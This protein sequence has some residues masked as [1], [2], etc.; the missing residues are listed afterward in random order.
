MYCGV[1]P[2]LFGWANLDMYVWL[3]FE[4]SIPTLLVLVQKTFL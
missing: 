4:D 3:V 1:I 2:N